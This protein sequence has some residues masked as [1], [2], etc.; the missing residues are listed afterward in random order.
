MKFLMVIEVAVIEC[1]VHGMLSELDGLHIVLVVVLVVKLGVVRVVRLIPIVSV[2]VS[3]AVVTRCL[4]WCR[5][6]VVAV[7]AI[8][9]FF[10]M[11]DDRHSCFNDNIMMCNN[12]LMVDHNRLFMHNSI[13]M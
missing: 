8:C 9:F 6:M 4:V 5:F 13:M 10:V 7:I 2:I 12:R 3:V 11:M 1:T